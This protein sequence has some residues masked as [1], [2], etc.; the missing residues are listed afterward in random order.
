[1]IEKITIGKE[2]FSFMLTYGV[3]ERVALD[4]GFTLGE[5]EKL[6][7]QGRISVIFDLVA[8]G[9]CVADDSAALTGRDIDKRVGFSGKRLKQVTDF[10]TDYIQVMMDEMNADLEDGAVPDRPGKH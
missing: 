6:L 3:M 7:A 9:I 1:M 2:T 4:N 5:L 10:I 8:A